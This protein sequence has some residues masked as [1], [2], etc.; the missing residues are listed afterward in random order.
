MNKRN[1]LHHLSKFAPGSSLISLKKRALTKRIYEICTIAVCPVFI[2]GA[3][4]NITLENR[5]TGFKFGLRQLV[6]TN[7]IYLTQIF[8]RS[9]RQ[10]FYSVP[11]GVFLSQ[12]EYI[13]H[14]FK[15]TSF[16]DF[17]MCLSGYNYFA[18]S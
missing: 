3:E 8:L 7:F 1:T 14:M 6:V 5:I 12:T 4:Q 15:K 10:L 9:W 18:L 17:M 16:R 13:Y 2:D 11:I